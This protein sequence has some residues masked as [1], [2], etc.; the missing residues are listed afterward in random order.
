[1]DIEHRNNVSRVIDRLEVLE[2]LFEFYG[3]AR[4]KT[5]FNEDSING[6]CLILRDC[7]AELR[8]AVK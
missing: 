2:N 5:G 1:M 7:V 3:Y 6:L 4:E 8:K